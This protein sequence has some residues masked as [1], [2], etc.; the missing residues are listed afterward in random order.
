MQKQPLAYDHTNPVAKSPTSKG[1]QIAE[2]LDAVLA[3]PDDRKEMAL[4]ILRGEDLLREP[5]TARQ[6]QEPYLSLREIAQRV[7]VSACSLW[8]WGIPGHEL[9]GRRRFRLSEVHE[10]LKSEEFQ[11]HAAALRAERR[12]S[13]ESS[14][15][16]RSSPSK[17]AGI[18]R[19]QTL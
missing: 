3:A 2:I 11:R 19:N 6:T 18:S 15:S 5:P 14:E 7:G 13:K 4:Q 10:Y 16:M 9:G 12:R 8:R 17:L 1:T